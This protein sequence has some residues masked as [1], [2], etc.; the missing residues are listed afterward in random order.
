[1]KAERVY[2]QAGIAGKVYETASKHMI[3]GLGVHPPI[4]R[5]PA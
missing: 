2:A 5:I 3:A 4:L 1:M